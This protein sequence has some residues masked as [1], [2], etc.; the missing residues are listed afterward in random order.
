MESLA[1][2][3]GNVTGFM[4]FEYS[5]GGKWIELLREI[6]PSVTRVAVLRDPVQGGGNMQ[7]AAIQA[8]APL[9]RMEV[10]PINVR[11]AARD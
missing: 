3:G 2:P 11:E 8:V 9:L 4:N 1:Q 10:H 7:F 6:A 5:M